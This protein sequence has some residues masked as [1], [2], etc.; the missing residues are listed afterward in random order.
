MKDVWSKK[1]QGQQDQDKK[2][3]EEEKRNRK[4]QRLGSC[5]CLVSSSMS[6]YTHAAMQRSMLQCL[7]CLHRF[8][9]L[10][11]SS[12]YALQSFI[13]CQC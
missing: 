1:K 13:I 11:I 10:T 3:E 6:K 12:T 7:E 8:K 5:L 2:D 4:K 9:T